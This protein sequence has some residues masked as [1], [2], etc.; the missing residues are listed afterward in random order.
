M[1]CCSYLCVKPLAT[2]AYLNS[3]GLLLRALPVLVSEHY[4]TGI[5]ESAAELHL[6]LLM[7]VPTPP[8]LTSAAGASRH[9]LG[10]LSN[11]VGSESLGHPPSLSDC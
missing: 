7:H 2:A 8:F 6:A 5:A 9:S 4:N 1:K 11:R 3:I 10:L